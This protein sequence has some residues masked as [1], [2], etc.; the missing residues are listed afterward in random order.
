MTIKEKRDILTDYCVCTG[1][2]K[3]VLNHK[4]WEHYCGDCDDNKCLYL[5]S[6]TEKELDRALELVAETPYFKPVVGAPK[7]CI[8][9]EPCVLEQVTEDADTVIKIKSN[10]KI[11]RLII[12][13]AEE[14]KA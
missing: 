8:E 9:P 7:P 13:F 6:A 3:C 1:C 14:V 12:E 5:A 4:Q 2:E 11:N 10:R